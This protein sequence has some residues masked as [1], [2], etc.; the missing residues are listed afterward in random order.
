MKK[1]LFVVLVF[2]LLLPALSQARDFKVY[3]YKT[4]ETGEIELVYWA[5]Y[6]AKSDLGM[7][8]FGVT[9]DREELWAH[10]LEVE[11]G[12]TD[13]FTVAAYADFEQ[14]SGEDFEFVQSRIIAARY[15]FGEPG[16]RFFDTAVYV[17]YYLPRRGWQD[18]A[19]EKLE[20][21]LILEKDL[22]GKA[23]TLNPRI[24]KV[25]SGPDIEEGLEFEYGISLYSPW[26]GKFK[27]G[28]EAYGSIGELVDVK[29]M[30]R[31]K[32]YL[33]PAVTWKF[34][35]HWKWNLGS[36]FGLTD[37]SDDVVFKSIVEW[38]L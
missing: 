17:E 7:K 8:Y 3:G 32:H 37:A 6:V 1:N 13:R 35:E 30:D 23:L 28:L 27:W 26:H 15:R 25:T 38:E 16:E 9:V 12:V 20:L 29:P 19:K 10:T 2:G 21:R 4:P 5:D 33:V 14:P 11:Y 34:A 31:Q 18:K 36:A 22:G 24:E